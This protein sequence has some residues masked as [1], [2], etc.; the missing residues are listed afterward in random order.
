MINRPLYIFHDWNLNNSLFDYLIWN[1]PNNFNRNL[2]YD[3]LDN[4]NEYFFD[5]RSKEKCKIIYLFTPR[6]IQLGVQQSFQL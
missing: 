5:Y 6:L 1:L 2:S 4:V 3:F